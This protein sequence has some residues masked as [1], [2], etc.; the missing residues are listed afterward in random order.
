MCI[1]RPSTLKVGR[2]SFAA[3]LLSWYYEDAFASPRGDGLSHLLE[4]S[5]IHANNRMRRSRP[6]RLGAGHSRSEVPPRHGHYH[7]PAHEDP[8]HRRAL[9]RPPGLGHLRLPLREGGTV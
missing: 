1:I 7:L 9:A 8:P 5:E 3:W 2:T 6:R 4:K